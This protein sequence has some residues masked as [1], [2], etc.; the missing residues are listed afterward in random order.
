MRTV[1][2]HSAFLVD[3]HAER[4]SVCP[5]ACRRENGA[6]RIAIHTFISDPPRCPGIF[7]MR[8]VYHRCPPMSIMSIYDEVD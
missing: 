7:E 1:L 8:K 5:Q 6:S 3:R 4:A 2:L